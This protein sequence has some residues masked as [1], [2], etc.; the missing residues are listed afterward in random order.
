[1]NSKKLL[2]KA[3]LARRQGIINLIIFL[4]WEFVI[5]IGSILFLFYLFITFLFDSKRVQ[6]LGISESIKEVATDSILILIVMGLLP[7]LIGGICIEILYR[8]YK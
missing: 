7:A 6:T 8:R 5:K 4:V 3:L 2:E 1:M